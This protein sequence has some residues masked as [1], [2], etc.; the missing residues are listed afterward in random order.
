MAENVSPLTQRAMRLGMVCALIS[1]ILYGLWPPCARGVYAEGGN[2]TLVMLVN[3]FLRAV[4]MGLFCV[5]KKQRLFATRT[6]FRQGL[7]GGLFQALAVI[8]I[9]KA[10]E[11]LPGPVAIIII[12]SHTLMLLFFM[13][14]RREIKLDV[15][16]VSSTIIALIGLTFVVD[17]WHH[18]SG[19][20]LIGILCAFGAAI[21]TVMRLYVFGQQTKDRHPIV[22]GAENFISAS[23]FL[24]PFIFIELP[25]LPTSRLGYG[26]LTLGS[27][28]S[29]VATFSMFYGISLLGAFRYS[30]LLKMEPLFTALFSIF[31]I[32]EIL[33]PQQYLGMIFVIGSL[34][35]YQVFDHRRNRLKIGDPTLTET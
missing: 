13:A 27:T 8:G 9:Y 29:V 10:T 20:H 18:Q 2:A 30:L 31:L 16:T 25:Q 22:V 14:W 11:Y 6:D 7:F 23:V 33:K 26:Y 28:T 35:L 34:V 12:F 24:L 4:V 15:I 3:T 32:G 21:A 19:G 1:A 17:V 5:V